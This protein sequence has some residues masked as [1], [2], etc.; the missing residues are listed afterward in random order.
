M[1]ESERFKITSEDFAD[2]IISNTNRDDFLR[3]YPDSSVSLNFANSS[4]VHIPVENMDFDSIN[5]FGY[6]SI[7]ACFGLLTADSIIHDI[8]LGDLPEPFQIKDGY[9]GKEVLVGFIDTGI[10]YRNTAF[11]KSDGTSR[12]LSI[13]DQTIE[14]TNYPEGFFYG[15]QYGNDQINTALTAADPL[16]IVPSIDEIGH[17]TILAGIAGGNPNAS[18]G[19]S[20]VAVDINIAMVKLKPAKNYLK[21][22]FLIPPQ[23][24]CFQENDIING[25][26]YLNQLANQ[27]KKPLVL[28][29]GIGTS[30]SDHT[31]NRALSRYLSS[32]G[33][34]PGRGIVVSAGN[35]SN[36]GSHYYGDIKPPNSFDDVVL[37]VGKDTYGFTLQFW[38]TSPNLF[39]IDLYGPDGEF[40]SRVPPSPN[41]SI[42]F[43]LEDMSIIIDSQI[44]EPFT[45]EQFIVMRFSNPI[46][47]DWHFYV[48]GLKGDLPMRFHFWLPLHNFLTPGTVFGNPNNYTTIIAPGNN[49]SLICATAYNPQNATLYFYASKGNTITNYPKPDITAPGVNSVSPFINNTY[50]TAT[51]TSISSAYIAGV[52]TLLMEWGITNGNYTEMNNTLL[53]KIITQSASRR[54]EESYPNPD[55]GYG[56]VDISKLGSV[57]NSILRVQEMK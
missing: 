8:N 25:V 22:F 35:E 57:I 24:I 9:S 42:I 20:G 47:G 34:L 5:R 44:K 31:G 26:T 27:L 40:I 15:T 16:A 37:T 38:G 29:L 21:E 36:R 6:N 48:Y 41:K 19:F 10:D 51:G 30:Q 23:S 55:W 39:W 52:L 13:W 11:I 4:I 49:S 50:V 32:M 1:T 56:I 46:P 2:L 17:G 7:P 28:C 54:P 14:S 53:K 45:T 3:T 43:V 18:Y 33:E 12:I